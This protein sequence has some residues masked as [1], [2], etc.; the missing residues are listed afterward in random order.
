MIG[1]PCAPDR[2]K[3]WASTKYTPTRADLLFAETL[4]ER[5]GMARGIVRV[6]ACRI[7]EG[8]PW[9]AE[10]EGLNPFLSLDL[11]LEAGREKFIGN[12][13]ASLHGAVSDGKRQKTR[14]FKERKVAGCKR[15]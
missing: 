5:N 1:A 6:D 11:L 4:V 7:K 12:F 14:F 9:L 8:A 2:N 3:R 13:I 10:L 15:P